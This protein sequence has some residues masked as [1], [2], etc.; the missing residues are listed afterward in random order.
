MKL[1]FCFFYLDL[2][3][4]TIFRTSV[5]G[6]PVVMSTDLEFN[7]YI[8]NQEGRLAELWSM[9]SFAKLFGQEGENK[10]NAV[11]L[12]HKLMRSLVLGHFGA[13]SL[14]EKSLPQIEEFVNKTLQTWSSQNSIEV[15]HA[16]SVVS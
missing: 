11:G 6:R 8:V 15:K 2:R 7:H 1:C 14:K 13:E 10:T 12:V 16:A 3:Y 4:G 5:A 9:D